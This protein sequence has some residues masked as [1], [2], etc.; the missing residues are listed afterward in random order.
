MARIPSLEI[1]NAPQQSRPLMEAVQK[2]LGFVPNIYK[3]LANAPAVLE[4]FLGFGQ[5]LGQGTL[6]AKL[7]EQIALTIAGA[8]TCDYC[9]SAHTAIG[10]KLGLDDAELTANL[11]ADSSDPKTKAALTFARAINDRE[12]FVTDEQLRAVREAGY[13]DQQIV[14]IFAETLKNVFTNYFNHLAETEI[15]FPVVKAG[16]PAAA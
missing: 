16:D 10:K 2:K 7:R 11:R 5:A 15:D 4:G 12:G 9:A 8:N 13:D 3:S 14:E 1:E 6:P